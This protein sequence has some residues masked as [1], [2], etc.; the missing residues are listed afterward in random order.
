[1]ASPEIDVSYRRGVHLPEIDLW[2]DP[3]GRKEVAFVSHAHADHFARHQRI[4]CSRQTYE[5]IKARYGAGSAD[6]TALEFGEI[7]DFNGW[8]YQLLPAGHIFGSAQIHL[9]RPD[10]ASVLYTGDFKTRA[11]L[12]CE[13]AQ[14]IAADTLIMETTYG[15]LQYVFPPTE[16][17][18]DAMIK[19]ATEA[20]E[21]GEVPVLLGYSLGKAQEILS[22]LK[23]A[24]LPVMLHK[25]VMKM[26]EVYR[27]FATEFPTFEEF[28]P[29]RVE[30]H[31]LIVPPSVARSQQIRRIKNKRL[32]MISGWALN[33]GSKFRYQ[34][35]EVFPLS[36]HADYPGLMDAVEAVQPKRV[37][38]L[39][40]FAEEFARDLRGKGIEAW[41]LLGDNQM[42]LTLADGGAD[43][44]S[45]GNTES[46]SKHREV[47]DADDQF[48][49][50]VHTAE[51][52]AAMTGKLRKVE[53]LAAFLRD[54]EG[55][56]LQ[57]AATFLTGH[58]FEQAS[59]N[60]ALQVGWRLIRR[61]VLQ[62]SKLNEGEY[63]KITQGQNDVGRATY[64]AL[65]EGHGALVP[66]SQ[67]FREMK[68]LFTRLREVRGPTA[69]GAV[70]AEALEEFR[71]V[72]AQ[73]V[74][75]IL[76]NDLRIGL[77]EGLLEEAVA[78]AFSVKAA[79][80]REA[81]MLLGSIGKVAV[82]ARENRL[83]DA[84]VQAFAPVKVML[85]SPEETAEDIVK[86]AEGWNEAKGESQETESAFAVW[87]EDKFDG[88]R[89][90]IH[91]SGNRAEIFSRD[92]RPM[93]AEFPELVAQAAE[94]GD[95]V[96]LDGEI[97]AFAEGKKLTFFDL[98]KRL[99]R[100]NESDL[101][102]GPSIP[103]RY[104]IFD[105]LWRNG[106]S[107]LKVPLRERR[108]ELE[109]LSLP[110][111]FELANV[112]SAHSATEVDDAFK[113]A[114]QRENEGLIAKDPGSLYLPGRRGKSWLKLKKAFSTLDCVVVAAEQG[115]GKR[116]HVISDYTFAVRDERT[117]ELLVIGKAYSGLT[118]MEIE[119]LTE[120]FIEHTIEKKRQKRFVTPNVVLEI[121]FDSIQP[122]KRHNSGLSLRFPRIAAIRRD[123]TVKEIDTLAY[124]RQLAEVS[125]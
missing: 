47:L 7:A 37:L 94:L 13:A 9:T 14:F 54:L 33:P 24:G 73:Y 81:S 122:S 49:Q 53:I 74:V 116:S 110:V 87:L 1:M 112:H 82:L 25:S 21:D 38:T 106:Q 104:V 77:K 11:G 115:H 60:R 50:F 8:K 100:R 40:G 86:R 76:S 97:I 61:V 2:L 46:S 98:Q 78:E 16:E 83:Q 34:V 27:Q 18:V 96:I 6:V 51:R 118:D 85:A 69:K 105:L 45:D 123:K 32:A 92:L 67:T 19:F 29:A 114:R 30:G 22:S 28:E 58:A 108:E 39:H 72:E 107:L 70:L 102:L 90:Q 20:I 10:G 55:E 64:L 95:D 66:K 88:I 124:A 42:E 113:A 125:A 75:K 79:E 41:S 31:A 44:G 121:A 56:D 65:E 63:R 120:H 103:V 109:K 26:T 52:I 17:V 62:V 101:F 93:T 80:V 5:L 57:T 71:P 117:E 59:E 84:S 3:D 111:Q 89:A 91:R 119:E 4:L 23:N 48:G 35:D 12:S 36:D 99:G 15:R 43:T 68:A